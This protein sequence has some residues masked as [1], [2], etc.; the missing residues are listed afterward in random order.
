MKQCST[1]D[2]ILYI[3]ALID[4]EPL[5]PGRLIGVPIL[6]DPCTTLNLSWTSPDQ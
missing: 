5:L 3:L 1:L 2:R 4:G 6:D